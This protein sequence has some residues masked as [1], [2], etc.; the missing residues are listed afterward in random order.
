[1]SFIDV[2]TILVLK[3]LESENSEISDEEDIESDK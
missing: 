3:Y 1:M 2:L